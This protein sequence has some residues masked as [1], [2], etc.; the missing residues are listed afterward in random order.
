M[1]RRIIIMFTVLFFAF[2]GQ[3]LRAEETIK[4]GYVNAI[5]IFDSTKMGKKSKAALEDY[6]SA[7]QKL[8][9][10]EEEELKKIEE[11]L[12]KQGALLT[13]DAKREKET[14]LQKKLA[15]YQKK[16][17]D[18]NKEIQ[19]KKSEIIKDFN[20]N[21]EEAVKKIAEKEG[22]KLVLDHNPDIGTIVYASSS[23]DITAKTIE[24]LDKSQK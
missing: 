1:V 10:Q 6:I 7:R 2:T 22:Y 20:H 17:V 12:T 16:A 13:P 18:L 23:M 5:K 21:M 9:N 19:D 8:V 24:E 14:Q 15:Q 4:I 3:A 11:D